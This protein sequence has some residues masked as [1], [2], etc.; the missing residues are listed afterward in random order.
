MMRAGALRTS[1]QVAQGLRTWLHDM[2]SAW[3]PA[4]DAHTAAFCRHRVSALADEAVLQAKLEGDLGTSSTRSW[5]PLGHVLAVVTEQ[6]HLGVVAAMVAAA[7]TGNRLTLKARHHLKVLH[8][9]RDALGWTEAQCRIA[10]WDSEGQD[11]E[12]LLRD[13]QGVLMA[14][15]E[16]LIRHYRRVAR[17]GVRLIE[18][19]PRSSAA[20][21]PCWP[22]DPHEQSALVS[23]LVHDT[24]LFGQAVCSS[25]Q[26]VMVPD[27]AVAQ[28]LLQALQARLDDL[29]P[30][31]ERERLLQWRTVQELNL[32]QGLNADIQVAWSAHSGWAAA[33]MDVADA[34]RLPRGF[35]LIVGDMACLVQQD[36]MLQTLGV[37]PDAGALGAEVHAFHCSTL[38]RMHERPLLAPHDGQFELAQWVYFV[39]QEPAG[40][41]SGRQGA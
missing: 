36:N 19:G 10:D 16:S 32:M 35:R 8:Q 23:A 2:G 24:V 3:P 30:L 9:L 34:G 18:Y 5:R 25:P 41:T 6:D 17:P 11:D 28:A 31:G 33:I 13:V 22:T 21:V 29:P 27:K 14:G 38:G 37:W 1:A 20:L 7:L 26:W 4:F 40:F 12:A 39:S 15:G